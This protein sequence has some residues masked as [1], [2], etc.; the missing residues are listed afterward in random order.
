MLRWILT[1][2][3]FPNQMAVIPSLKEIQRSSHILRDDQTKKAASSERISRYTLLHS[4]PQSPLTPLPLS[5]Q[6]MSSIPAAKTENNNTNVQ[7]PLPVLL[8]HSFVQRRPDLEDLP[9]EVFDSV[10]TLVKLFCDG[11]MAIPSNS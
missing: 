7:I 5:Q 9:T 11:V 10:H 6:A 1:I 2:L 8:K 3:K 4:A